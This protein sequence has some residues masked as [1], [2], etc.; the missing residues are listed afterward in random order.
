MV[1]HHTVRKKCDAEAGDRRGED[2][3]EAVVI[4]VAMKKHRAFRGSVD[5]VVNQSRSV[6]SST[7]RHDDAQNAM[8]MPLR[9]PMNSVLFK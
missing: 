9:R 3:H 8:V 5:D 7:P 6:R 4:S 1:R 2:T